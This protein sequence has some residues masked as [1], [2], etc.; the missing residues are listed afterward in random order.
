MQTKGYLVFVPFGNVASMEYGNN[1]QPDMATVAT[2]PGHLAGPFRVD[3]PIVDKSGGDAEEFTPAEAGHAPV[4][5]RQHKQAMVRDLYRRGWSYLL[6]AQAL[7][8]SDDETRTAL[9][10]S[11]AIR[12][13]PSRTG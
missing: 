6:I 4:L 10:S 2:T 5:A 12:D 9:M 3:G 8:L 11:A 13:E 7:S 1:G